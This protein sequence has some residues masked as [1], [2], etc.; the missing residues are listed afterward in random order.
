MATLVWSFVTSLL[1]LAR[2]ALCFDCSA[3]IAITVRAM[4]WTLGYA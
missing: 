2:S 4:I 3:E 1:M